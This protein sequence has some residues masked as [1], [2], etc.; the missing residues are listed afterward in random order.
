MNRLREARTYVA[1]WGTYMLAFWLASV[2][3]A[4][5]LFSTAFS[6]GGAV[7]DAALRGMFDVSQHG[8]SGILE[9]WM[10]EL[11]RAAPMLIPGAGV[12]WGFVVAF[13]SYPLFSILA[14]PGYL[15]GFDYGILLLLVLQPVLAANVL[16]HVILMRY[17]IMWAR[18]LWN[19]RG[20]E[21][22][23]LEV[24]KGLAKPTAMAFGVA[25]GCLFLAA[26]ITYVATGDSYSP[27]A[28]HMEMIQEGAAEKMVIV[29][30]ETIMLLFGNP[31]FDPDWDEVQEALL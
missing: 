21:D 20:M 29:I 1:L 28:M 19:M 26:T 13:T 17:S 16:A 10:H 18:A 31:E 6:G 4:V 8:T 24:V 7:F 14:S 27:A 5:V 15:G 12:A 9:I 30:Q 22:G 3:F 2:L 23:R 11:M 25:A